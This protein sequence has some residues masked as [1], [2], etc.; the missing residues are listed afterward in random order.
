MPYSSVQAETTLQDVADKALFGEDVWCWVEGAPRRIIHKLDVER[1]LAMELGHL[2]VASIAWT[3]SNL[4]ATN[5]PWFPPTRRVKP[6]AEPVASIDLQKRLC[7]FFPTKFVAA[8]VEMQSLFKTLGVQ[9]YLI[10]GLPRDLVMT[11]ERRQDL[12]DVDITIVGDAIAVAE[13]LDKLSKN[14]DLQQTYPEFGTAKLTYKE[15]LSLDLASTR[16]ETYAHCG[17][18][19]TVTE[20]GTPLNADVLRRDFTMNT[21][22]LSINQL[23]LVEDFTNGLEDVEHSQV[24]LLHGASFFEDPSR[25]LRAYKFAS[26]LDFA[27]GTETQQLIRAFTEYANA[28]HYKGGGARIREG[29]EEWWSLPESSLKH[30][31]MCNW[32]QSGGLR[33]IA[34]VPDD[35]H[36]TSEPAFFNIAE[37]GWR[38]Q[39]AVEELLNANLPQEETNLR[40]R[41]WLQ[42]CCWLWACLPD[43]TVRNEFATRLELNRE[44]RDC[45]ND[46]VTLW[47]TQLLATLTPE[48]GPVEIYNLFHKRHPVAC[49]AALLLL[50]AP[51]PATEAFLRYWNHY[52][53]Q[54]PIL[55]GKDLLCLGVQ[56][57]PELGEIRNT[58]LKERLEGHL[59]SR[60]DEV[61][62][63]EHA[64]EE[65]RAVTTPPEEASPA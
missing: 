52:R 43:E 20:R 36:D 60:E 19:P 9:G 2:P 59:E 48:M 26:R 56:Q 23:G 3:P 40:Q 17:V 41:Y 47:D 39:T 27:I 14:F 42:Y 34:A 16:K 5:W 28:A 12:E 53:N 57:G 13:Q 37:A 63:V 45:V 38:H 65:Q 51:L 61:T 58:L 44:E 30:F 15:A 32:L 54:Q 25:I 7:E 10:G 1:M 31:Y 8:L 18:L 55:D 21:L 4:E 22:A 49:I 6:D 62:F 11:V 64:L 35:M 46:F 33:L 29:L 24:Q 50:E